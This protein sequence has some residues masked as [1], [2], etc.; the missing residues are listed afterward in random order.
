MARKIP[1]GYESIPEYIRGGV[2]YRVKLLNHSEEFWVFRE[3]KR[4]ELRPVAKKFVGPYY[5][6]E[7]ESVRKIRKGAA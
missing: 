2:W 4:K 5:E 7:I 6:D 1:K 3:L